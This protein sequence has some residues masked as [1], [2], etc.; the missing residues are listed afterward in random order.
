MWPSIEE[1]GLRMSCKVTSAVLGED[2]TKENTPAGAILE[3]DIHLHQPG[4]WQ[5][6]AGNTTVFVSETADAGWKLERIAFDQE[7]E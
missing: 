6:S 5:T 1:K 3:T 7:P 2:L 4:R